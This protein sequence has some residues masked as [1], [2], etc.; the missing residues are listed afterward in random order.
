MASHI[1]ILVIIDIL[2]AFIVLPFK[3]GWW[4]CLDNYSRTH[5]IGDIN[6][7]NNVVDLCTLV[8]DLRLFIIFFFKLVT[9]ENLCAHVRKRGKSFVGFQMHLRKVNP[10]TGMWERERDRE[11]ESD[12]NQFFWFWNAYESSNFGHCSDFIIYLVT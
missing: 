3:H 11:R 8:A 7:F 9:C 10:A 2:E 4:K 1:G 6:I 12:V 5:N